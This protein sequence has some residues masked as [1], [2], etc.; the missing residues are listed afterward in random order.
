MHA[1]GSYTYIRS[2]EVHVRN[3][4]PKVHNALHTPTT[5]YT[6]SDLLLNMEVN[7]VKHA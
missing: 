2:L 5:T 3:E 4:L 1:V 7:I 6:S